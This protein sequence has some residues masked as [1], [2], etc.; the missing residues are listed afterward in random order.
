[1]KIF[2]QNAF[3]YKRQFFIKFFVKCGNSKHSCIKINNDICIFASILH[4]TSP[5]THFFGM[6]KV[7][8]TRKQHDNEAPKK[9]KSLTVAQK[10]EICLKKISTPSLK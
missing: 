2:S 4:F 5:H 1:M 10:K 7:V 8:N 6:P 3:Y 9:R